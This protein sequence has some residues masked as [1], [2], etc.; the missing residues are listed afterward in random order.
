MIY[1][2]G[3]DIVKISRFENVSKNFM[4][5]CFTEAEREYLNGKRASSA[6]GLFTAKE[7]VV[8]AMGT[9]FKGFWPVDVEI[10]HNADGKPEAVLHRKAARL[11]D[12]RDIGRIWLSISHS[13][14]D[15]VAF[16]VA[17]T[18]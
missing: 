4:E 1:G 14:T 3:T 15:A 18:V 13:E 9:G 8:K 12:E 17:E 16:A 2:V 5:K 11:A 10:A 6:A 7:A